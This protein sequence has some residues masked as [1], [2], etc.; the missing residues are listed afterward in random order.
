MESLADSVLLTNTTLKAFD[1]QVENSIEALNSLHS[2]TIRTPLDLK[3]ISSA[4]KN[5][6]ASMRNFIESTNRSGQDLEDYKQTILDLSLALVGGQVSLGRTANSAGVSVRINN[7][8][9]SINSVN[10]GELSL[11]FQYQ[12]NTGNLLVA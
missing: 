7:L 3:K 12:T 9:S 8:M 10:C 5:A 1:I 11:G 4:M 2:S 6:G